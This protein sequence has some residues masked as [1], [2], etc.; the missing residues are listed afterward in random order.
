MTDIYHNHLDVDR[1]DCS[2]V[3]FGKDASVTGKVIMAHN[4]DDTDVYVQTH[5][6]PRKEHK[7]GEMVVFEDG[8]AIIEGM[9][10]L[11]KAKELASYI[12]IGGLK[13][14]RVLDYSTHV[15]RDVATGETGTIDLPAANVLTWQL[16]GGAQVIVRPSGTEPKI[17]VYYSTK[18][19]SAA[20]SAAAQA[21]CAADMHR[22][23]GR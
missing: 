15:I 9:G 16:E 20:E 5:L 8:K 14:T 4:E 6:V 21:A 19:A 3:I 23:L 17:K 11:D 22:L 12:R 18:G 7:E 1:G 13:V 2:T 10:D